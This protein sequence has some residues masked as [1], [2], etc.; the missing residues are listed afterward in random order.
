MKTAFETAIQHT[1]HRVVVTAMGD[2]DAA[3]EPSLRRVPD[4]VP[5][6]TTV[7]LIDVH[8]VPFMDSAGL[9]LLLDLHRR[10]ELG[11]LRVLVVGWQ[12][13]P[14][15]LMSRVAG[16]PADGDGPYAVRHSTLVG[17]RRMIRQRTEHQRAEHQR[18]AADRAGNPPLPLR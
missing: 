4:A 17:F 18:T 5:A 10:L 1:A 16:L 14:Q 8:G 7:A 13:Q 2:L 15:R 11:G 3:A 9:L 6:G 12:P